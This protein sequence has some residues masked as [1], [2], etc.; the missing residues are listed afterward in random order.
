MS[1]PS[2][3]LRLGQVGQVSGVGRLLGGDPRPAL[4][5]D[6]LPGSQRLDALAS[7]SVP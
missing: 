7:R 1:R 2:M 4:G 3:V 5:Q 6:V